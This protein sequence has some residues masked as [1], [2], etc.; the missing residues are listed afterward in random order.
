MKIHLR[1]RFFSCFIFSLALSLYSCRSYNQNI[2]FKTSGDINAQKLQRSVATAERNYIIQPNDYIDVRVYTNKGERIFDPNGELPF[3]TPGGGAN[4]GASRN[5]LRGAQGGQ[6]NANQGGQNSQN[7]N[8][9][10]FLV[11][12]DGTVKLP[13]VEYV[14]V[15]G[16][17][18]L[19]TDSLLQTL[20]ATYYVEP[21]VA[22]RVTNNR[23]FV[24]G[25][26]GGNVIQMTNDNMNLFEVLAQAGGVTRDGKAQNIRI[27][28]DYLNHDPVVQIVD[29]STIDGMKKASLHVE[30]NDV[31][32]IEPNQRLFFELLRDVAPVINTFVGVV[33]TYL[34]IKNL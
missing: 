4:Q 6:N 7:Y 17:T 2:M 16:L 3:G 12:H 8:N 21:F 33:S 5:T 18:L 1:L 28:R 25:A 11:Q 26:T 19:Q 30:P 10:E 22:T 24:L 20:Y 9:K 13:M 31:V 15:A 27:I 14:K 29:L 34:L 23:I 32:Y